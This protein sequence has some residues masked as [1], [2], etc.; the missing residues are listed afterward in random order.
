MRFM[1]GE[2]FL[3]GLPRHPKPR[4]GCIQ[5]YLERLTHLWYRHFQNLHHHEDLSFR[6][7]ELCQ[8]VHAFD[9]DRLWTP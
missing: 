8:D 6:L 3:E 7:V 2:R 4:I 1:P 5:R 9:V